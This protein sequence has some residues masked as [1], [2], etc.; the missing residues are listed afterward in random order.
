MAPMSSALHDRVTVD[1][2][3]AYR[4]V[5]R[6]AA[7]DLWRAVLEDQSGKVAAGYRV[8]GDAGGRARDG[9]GTWW[10]QHRWAAT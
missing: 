4:G 10:R 7:A 8:L 1:D 9:L 3:I 6:P 5:V 2:E